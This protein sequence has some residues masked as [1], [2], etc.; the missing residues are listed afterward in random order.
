MTELRPLAYEDVLYVAQNMRQADKDEIYATRWNDSAEQLAAD[1]MLVPQMCWTACKDGRPV[2]AFGAIPI[3]PGVWTVWMF[4]T[5]EWPSVALLV[6]RHIIKKM[7]PS[8]KTGSKTF[9]RGECKSHSLHHVA[10]RWLEYLGASKESIAYKYGKNG[11][12]FF[13]FAW[14]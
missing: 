3:H 9:K 2:A 1:A 4:A 7:M 10:H 13:V 5:D 11:E 8:I 12:N 14:L 6:T